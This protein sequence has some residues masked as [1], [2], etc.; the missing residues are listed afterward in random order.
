MSEWLQAVESTT[1]P[2]RDFLVTARAARQFDSNAVP[3]LLHE[4]D[5]KDFEMGR[6]FGELFQII[7]GKRTYRRFDT[8]RHRQAI[9][10][11]ELLGPKG[12]AA[13]P[14]LV[15]RLSDSARAGEAADALAGICGIS[16]RWRNVQAGYSPGHF[17]PNTNE[18]SPQA[19]AN[20]A[21]LR[22]E[23][24]DHFTRAATNESWEIRRA[25]V[26]AMCRFTEDAATVAP[27]LVA[28]L[29][30]EVSLVR[31]LA[32]QCLGLIAREPDLAIPALINALEDP[33]DG[34]RAAAAKAVS[35]FH[36]DRRASNAVPL[37]QKL[38]AD[39]DGRV[40]DAAR[41]ALSKIAPNAVNQKS[42]FE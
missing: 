12:R 14:I 21:L 38:L 6:F 3:W 23:V 17:Y 19:E 10:G 7:S 35:N 37:L 15:E 20:R 36:G 26:V 11:I 32:A 18:L 25:V 39:P 13:M 31:M 24:L 30:D 33:E 16:E 40:R 5:A 29:R 41:R 4:L 42:E 28:R 8:V 27:L 22:R 1:F 9:V 2:S 34:V